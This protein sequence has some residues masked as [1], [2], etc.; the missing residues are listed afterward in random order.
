[1]GAIYILYNKLEMNLR[2][3]VLFP[4]PSYLINGNYKSTSSNRVG[5]PQ[6][7]T[8]FRGGYTAAA[9]NLKCNRK[10]RNVCFCDVKQ[11]ITHRL[12]QCL[13]GAITYLII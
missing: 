7:G 11:R 4:L 8:M 13:E 1:M 12:P 5:T 9:E 3:Y 2:N 6:D 10:I